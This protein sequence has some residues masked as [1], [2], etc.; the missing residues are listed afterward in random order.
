MEKEGLLLSEWRTVGGRRRKYYQVTDLGSQA[1]TRHT[2][3]WRAFTDR[4]LDL[5]DAP[6]APEAT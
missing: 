2:A 6:K 1:L 3:E 4:L 5:L